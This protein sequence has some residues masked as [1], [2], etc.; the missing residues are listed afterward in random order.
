MNSYAININNLTVTY[1]DTPALWDIDISIPQGILLAIVGPNGAGKTTLIKS[2]LGLVKPL[3]GCISFLGGSYK[4]HQRD[5]AYIPQRSHIDWDFPVNVLD[6]VLMGRYGH[7]GWIRRPTK[8]DSL[9]ALA[10]LEQVG[11]RNYA[12][13]H[14]SQLSYGQQQR[15]FLAR[16]LVQKAMIYIMDEPFVG[17]DTTTEK[18]IIT[19]LK[20]L[21]DEG[22]TIIVVHHDMQTLQAYFDWALLLNVKRIAYGPIEQVLIP[23]YLNAT[24]GNHNFWI[25]QHTSL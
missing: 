10:A 16:A 5:I 21:R 22:K 23:E 20:Q 14:I 17:V 6:V 15:I 2:M 25:N 3:A 24:Y 12:T 18:T 19:L 11:L 9:A 4:Q 7:L 8:H 1:K 13:R